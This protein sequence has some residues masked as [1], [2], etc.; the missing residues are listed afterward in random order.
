MGNG[1]SNPIAGALATNQ[2][3]SVLGD[4]KDGAQSTKQTEEAKKKV[5]ENDKRAKSRIT[6][7]EQKKKDREERKKKLASQWGEHRKANS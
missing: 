1:G 3:N 7:F 5:Q 6:E 2:F 4:A